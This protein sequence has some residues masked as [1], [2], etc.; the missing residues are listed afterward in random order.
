MSTSMPMANRTWK[1][2]T[3]R[4][5][6]GPSSTASRLGDFVVTAVNDGIYQADFDVI[7]GL[8]HRECERI[9][10]AAFR[11]VPPR[12]TMNAFLLQLDGRFALIDTGCGGTMG[13]TLGWGDIVHLPA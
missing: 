4:S 10:R 12:M 1:T 9:E 11:V 5:C 6:P 2:S 3:S 13:P 8:D 7:A